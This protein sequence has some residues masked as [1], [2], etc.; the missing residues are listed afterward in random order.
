MDNT[1]LIE[2]IENGT[3]T[4]KIIEIKSIYK[5]GKTTVQPVKNS[6]SGWYKGVERLSDEEKKGKKFWAEPSTKFILKEGVVLDLN[7]E[8]HRI[9]W[10]WVKH[11]PCLALTY[12]ECQTRPAAE[13]YVHLKNKEA[14]T[15]ISAKVLKHQ[16]LSFVLDDNP[17]NYALKAKLLGVN[18]DGEKEALAIKDFL[19]DRA[20]SA[21]EEIIR[22]YQDKMMALR[23]LVI[24]AI[25][26][27]K[28]RVDPDGGYRY[29]NLYLGMAEDSAVDYL[30]SPSNSK[31]RKL[32]ESEVNP[33]Y[34][35]SEED[36]NP[37]VTDLPRN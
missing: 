29:G 10:N 4:D 37:S 26:K 6:L 3:Y 2:Q 12:D 17:A 8:E 7:N 21:P 32:L 19:L 1:N 14:E 27:G 28:I 24:S 34:F 18:M 35:E 9:I 22:V 31:M 5:N 36:T 13:F 20:E 15:R 33:E 30:N 16:A 11:Q 25:E 23:L